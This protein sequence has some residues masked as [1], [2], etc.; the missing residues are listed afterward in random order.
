MNSTEIAKLA[1]VSRSTVSRVINN[2]S[3]VDPITKKKV[4]DVINKYGYTPN[5]SARNL[6]GKANNIIGLF[7]ADIVTDNVKEREFIGSDSPYNNRFIKEVIK[8][9]HSKGFLVLIDIITDNKDVSKMETYFSNKLVTGGI[10]IGFPYKNFE[11]EKLARTNS[12]VVLIDQLAINDP[13][14]DEFSL[15]NVDDEYGGY[16]QTNY[17]IN[18]GHKEIAF[19]EGDNRLS[20]IARKAGY[21]KALQESKINIDYNKIVY[22]GYKQKESYN[23]TTELL[24]NSNITAIVCAN[25][26]E[27]YGAFK[28]IKKKGLRIPEDIS[29]IGY[30]NLEFTNEIQ[31]NL[32]TCTIDVKDMASKAVNSSIVGDKKEEILKPYIIERKSVLKIK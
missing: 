23:V 28:A 12:H 16:I 18:H 7:I 9:A 31:L 4:Q 8:A 1:N 27:A 26:I 19:I 32:T 5:I 20:A 11:L 29:L 3:N 2:Y 13:N 6:A 21:I 15:I 17:L 30:D 25:D 22:G 14:R 10:F 24:D